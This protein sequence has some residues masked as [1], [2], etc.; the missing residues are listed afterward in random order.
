MKTLKSFNEVIDLYDF[1]LFDQWGV[2]H[3][4]YDKF[5]KAEQCLQKL[6]NLNKKVILISNSSNPIQHSIDNLK[7]IG[8]SQSLYDYCITSGEIA[9]QALLKDIYKKYGNQCYPLKLSKEKINIFK[10]NCVS[11]INNANFAMIADLTNNLNILDFVEDLDL[12]MKNKLPLFCSNPDYMVYDKKK[13]SMAGGT[14]AQLYEDMGGKVYRYGK[15]FR[16]I[17]ENIIKTQNIL[18]NSRVLVIGDS[19][20]HDIAGGNEMGFDGLWIKNGVHKPQLIKKAEI[21]PLI[22]KYKPKFAISDLKL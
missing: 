7:K 14:I 18:K 15:P 20:W 21:D 9:L 1:F 22:A 3:N 16:P 2:L 17:Y 12:M 4:G 8:Y 19:L 13:L 6:K 11:D 5:I 10:L